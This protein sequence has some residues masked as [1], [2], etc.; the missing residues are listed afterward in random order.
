MS[1]IN[2]IQLIKSRHCTAHH[3]HSANAASETSSYTLGHVG[4]QSIQVWKGCDNTLAAAISLHEILYGKGYPFFQIFIH[5]HYYIICIH[6]ISNAIGPLLFKQSDIHSI[7]NVTKDDN[8]NRSDNLPIQLSLWWDFNRTI[9][10]LDHTVTW[11]RHC[12]LCQGIYQFPKEDVPRA[13]S[14]FYVFAHCAF[15]TLGIFRAP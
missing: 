11:S 7:F 1:Y 15:W 5:S 2:N 4:I 10:I 13:V 14:R 12:T 3:A 8:N 9:V 6:A